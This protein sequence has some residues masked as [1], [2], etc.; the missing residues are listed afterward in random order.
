MDIH[1]GQMICEICSSTNFVKQDQYMVCHNCGVKYSVEEARKR[2]RDV[3]VDVTGS[4]VKVDS[5]RK[6]T[7]LFQLA[8]RSLENMD[9]KA[10]AK[11][12]KSILVLKPESWEAA[13]YSVYCMA[14]SPKKNG[15]AMQTACQSILN[16]INSTITLLQKE[17][18]NSDEQADCVADIAARCIVLIEQ[19]V[20]DATTWREEAC[21]E[22]E[23]LSENFVVW[24]S[25]A[26]LV[27]CFVDF[28]HEIGNVLHKN[29]GENPKIKNSIPNVWV[30]AIYHLDHSCLTWG[31]RN[32]KKGFYETKKTIESKIRIYDPTY[33]TEEKKGGCYV[34]TCVYGSYDCPEVWTLRRYRDD[35][36]AS[37][38]RGRLFIKTYYAISPTAVKWFGSTAWFR[39]FW[40]SRLDRM[41]KKL[42]D[43]GVENT[44]YEDRSIF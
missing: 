18:P 28:L 33:A 2:I 1:L 11:Y 22:N 10:A 29:F 4:T 39:K 43:R 20:R 24:H 44:A 12:Y 17:K 27:G 26:I 31:K 6:I 9:M 15:E 8:H 5:S 23:N 35:T 40:R 38:R 14:A 30:T 21:E 3:K 13:F 42:N 25:Y 19:Y 32:D 34:A 7:N 36:L 16:S 37:T 41:V